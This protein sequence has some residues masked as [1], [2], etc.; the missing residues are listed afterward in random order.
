MAGLA[1]LAAGTP[2]GWALAARGLA[3][4]SRRAWAQRA[5]L[6]PSVQQQR[7]VTRLA[8]PRADGLGA[9]KP[10][11][12]DLPEAEPSAESLVD[13]GLAESATV[14]ALASTASAH[15]KHVGFDE[16]DD[17]YPI[18][19]L[20]DEEGLSYDLDLSARGRE[21]KPLRHQEEASERKTQL[22]VLQ[23]LAALE[24]KEAG[25]RGRSR[26]R[27]PFE[28]PD[29]QPIRVRVLDVD[30]L[31][32]EDVHTAFMHTLVRRRPA[33]VCI[34]VAS[35]LAQ[36]RDNYGHNAYE[37]LL[38]DCGRLFGPIHGPEL[39]ALFAR[40]HATISVP[41]MVDYTRR[42]GTFSR[43]FI[44]GQVEKSLRP[45]FFDFMRY[46]EKGGVRPLPMVV[47]KPWALS[48]Y[49]RL[50]AK[51][52]VKSYLHEQLKL[53][54]HVPES[55]LKEHVADELPPEARLDERLSAAGS[56]KVPAPAPKEA[57]E[58][59][60]G[61]KEYRVKRPALL[62][63]IMEAE[64]SGEG[65]DMAAA[66]RARA[67]ALSGSTSSSSSSGARRSVPVGEDREEDSDSE[68]DEEFLSSQA[69]AELRDRFAMQYEHVVPDGVL[70]PED[71]L[72]AEGHD[73]G[74]GG[75]AA[76]M[77]DE[78]VLPER[79]WGRSRPSF[80]RHMYRA[81]RLNE[82]QWQQVPDPRGPRYKP[83]RRRK[84][85]G[86]RREERLREQMRDARPR[87]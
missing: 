12:D 69:D 37:N 57:A 38:R 71:A 46:E 83:R 5:V 67:K 29:D 20:G 81:Y 74:R 82:G 59:A 63:A 23:R 65:W 8:V 41:F 27:G 22:G 62:D 58:E 39:L 72:V 78:L 33:E 18:D 9:D 11:S 64:H 45:A 85:H 53:H 86:Q 79:Y 48:S 24:R 13:E 52:H 7:F 34:H 25:G 68:D 56:L 77:S 19:A 10:F 6:L 31:P 15:H 51:S 35:R 60:W 36:F 3:F 26:R 49:T 87:G 54:G 1:A 43:A 16:H 84:P 2:A 55:K 75:R 73:F 47:S 30:A 4:R 70:E 42:F 80:F 28:F 44:A 32:L 21:S 17:P 50:M 14:G 61:R 66:A 76:G 40:C